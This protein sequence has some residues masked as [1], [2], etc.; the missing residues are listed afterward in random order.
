MHYLLLKAVIEEISQNLIGHR[1]DQVLLLDKLTIALNLFHPAFGENYL[2][3]SADSELAAL[4]AVKK[5]PSFLNLINSFLSSCQNFL[6]G[7]RLT[8]VELPPW[9]RNV[10]LEF[11]NP[12]DLTKIHL[13]LEIMGKHSNILLVNQDLIIIDAI[14]RYGE[15]QSRYREVLPGVPYTPPPKPEAFLLSNLTY[16]T[17]SKIIM[18][19]PDLTLGDL[20]KKYIVGLGTILLN[21]VF[22]L[23]NLNLNLLCRQLTLAQIEAL[24]STLVEISN[25]KTAPVLYY[26]NNVPWYP[27]PFELITLKSFAKIPG[28]AN[29]VAVNY[30]L[31]HRNFREFNNLKLSLKGKV[32]KKLNNLKQRLAELEVKIKEYD[33]ASTLKN[34][35][36][37]LLTYQHQIPKGSSKIEIFDWEQNLISIPLDPAKSPVENAESYYKKYQKAKKGL[38]SAQTQLQAAK[39]ELEYYK[40][41]DFQI[42]T[43]QTLED[44]EDIKQELGLGE[45]PKNKKAK[46]SPPRFLTFTTSQGKKVFVG[47]SNLQNDYLTFKVAKDNDIWLHAKNIPGAHVILKSEGEPDEQSLVE[48]AIIAATYS[49][50]RQGKKIPVDFTLRKFVQKPA[51]AKPGFVIYRNEKTILVDPNPDLYIERLPGFTR[52]K[53]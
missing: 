11:T 51:G 1:V 37:L 20:F 40:T 33:N 21:E 47:K 14:K 31:Y 5:V 32:Q 10:H 43:A 6:K 44:L 7:K 53:P 28:S 18:Q 45:I 48:A 42:E 4:F 36:D 8:K 38:N 34:M 23:S 13:Y 17:F 19:N 22:L 30:Y 39:E 41:L 52:G 26:Q 9:E 12:K 3:L 24:F 46:K 35:G 15:S 25:K 50:A 49:R 2:Y 29:E 16:D 27:S